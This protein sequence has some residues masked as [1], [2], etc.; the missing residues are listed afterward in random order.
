MVTV[1]F[2]QSKINMYKNSVTIYRRTY[3]PH[4]FKNRE[5]WFVERKNVLTYKTNLE[6]EA[7][8]EEAFELTNAPKECLDEQSQVRQANLNYTGPSLSVGDVVRVES[9]IRVPG[10]NLIPDYYLC[11]SFGWEKLNSSETKM[12]VDFLKFLQEA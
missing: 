2:L 9:T 8:A 7:A 4:S 10:D 6:G 3:T 1:Y 11:K 12:F 5:E